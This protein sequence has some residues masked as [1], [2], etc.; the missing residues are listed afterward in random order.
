MSDSLRPHGLQP[1]TLLHPWDSPGRSIGV[2]CHFLLQRFFPT[3]GSNPGLL[4][5]RQTLYLL[6]LQGSPNFCIADTQV[7]CAPRIRQS[8]KAS[9]WG[10]PLLHSTYIN[11]LSFH[12][13]LLTFECVSASTIS[14]LRRL[15]HPVTWCLLGTKVCA[16][17]VSALG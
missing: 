12:E 7:H 1:T 4:Y 14:E 10:T 16:K 17:T 13:C 5:C 9:Q 15:A 3:Q 8:N 6:S 11:T 2:G